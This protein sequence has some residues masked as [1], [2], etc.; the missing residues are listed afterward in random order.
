MKTKILI[1][2]TVL[3]TTGIILV[4]IGLAVS[5]M[6]TKKSTETIKEYTALIIDEHEVRLISE[7]DTVTILLENSTV[8][9]G[10]GIIYIKNKKR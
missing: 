10:E 5:I 3:I 2:G 4:F 1:L 9:F 8:L 7:T 6:P